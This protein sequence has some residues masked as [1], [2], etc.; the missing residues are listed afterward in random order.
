M[1]EARALWKRAAARCLSHC[2]PS[3]RTQNGRGAQERENALCA[4]NSLCIRLYVRDRASHAFNFRKTLQHRRMFD[5]AYYP[6]RICERALA[7]LNTPRQTD[8]C[9]VVG[10]RKP[11][12]KNKFARLAA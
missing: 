5:G 8:E 11:R 6:M 1:H 10:L 2:C 9:D 7:Q 3:P 12:S 4:D